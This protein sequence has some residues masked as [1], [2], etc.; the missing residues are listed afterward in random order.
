MRRPSG[1]MLA[2]G[3]KVLRT[4]M[5]RGAEYLNRTLGA[6]IDR[7]PANH[8]ATTAPAMRSG[9]ATQSKR[10][11]RDGDRKISRR[12]GTAVPGVFHVVDVAPVSAAMNSDAE[13]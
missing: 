11:Y 2:R 3:P 1:E 12:D 7:L 9:A 13:L 4:R 6:G 8:P 10:R 5:P